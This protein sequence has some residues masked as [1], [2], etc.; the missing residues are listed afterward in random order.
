[1]PLVLTIQLLQ[2]ALAN[3]TNRCGDQA[4]NRV[5]GQLGNCTPTFCKACLELLGATTSY[6]HFDLTHRKYQ[7]VASLVV[8]VFCI[9][10]NSV[11]SHPDNFFAILRSTKTY[12]SKLN[13]PTSLH[14]VTT[15]ANVL[16]CL[17]LTTKQSSVVLQ[18]R[19]LFQLPASRRRI[20]LRAK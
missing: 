1:M 19:L 11:A 13:C 10:C 2:F 7:L 6:N 8:F 16:S 5:L 3:E 4:R 15:T 17:H 12:L 18:L 20:H 14:I 9:Q